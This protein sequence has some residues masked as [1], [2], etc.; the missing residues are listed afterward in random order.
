MNEHNENA[1]F[2]DWQQ[3]GKNISSSHLI[4][5]LQIVVVRFQIITLR[6]TASENSMYEHMK[7][8]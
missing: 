4:L 1:T 8:S 6:V 5:N 3:L 7:S 2:N